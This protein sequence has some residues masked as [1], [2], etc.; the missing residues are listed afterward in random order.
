MKKL[1]CLIG[2]VFLFNSSVA[3]AKD[4]APYYLSLTGMFLGLDDA[5]LEKDLE[6]AEIKFD[7]GF[8][9]SAE[10]GRK[11]GPLRAALEYGYK[12]TNIFHLK[13]ATGHDV[14]PGDLSIKN[15]MANI[16]Y[17][18]KLTK[19]KLTP[20][21]GG[22]AGWAWVKDGEGFMNDSAFAYQGMAGITYEINPTISLIAG[23][24]YFATAQ[25]KTELPLKTSKSHVRDSNGDRITNSA[26]ERQH[27][28]QHVS[29]GRTSSVHEGFESVGSETN[30]ESHNFE[31]GLRF[32][33]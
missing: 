14:V 24:K 32:A 21:I 6:G 11:F 3:F 25:V 4:N 30:I 5:S 22:G 23:Y 12:E 26:G 2:L 31:L 8:G 13:S 27:F 7:S 15:L 28:I 17:D 20:Y 19:G 33:F 18:Q 10:V 16:Y 9:V 1:I 29:S